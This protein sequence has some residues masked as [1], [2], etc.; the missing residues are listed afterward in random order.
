[1]AASH[2]DWLPEVLQGTDQSLV[3]QLSDPE[4]ALHSGGVESAADSPDKSNAAVIFMMQKVR[5]ETGS[6][7]KE[8][9]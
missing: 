5:K 4:Q 2:A 7:L 1:V 3:K 8:K 9:I 6:S